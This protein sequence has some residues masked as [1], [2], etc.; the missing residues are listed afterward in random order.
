MKYTTEIRRHS[1]V[2]DV[3]I[4]HTI[5]V[6]KLFESKPNF[7]ASQYEGLNTKMVYLRKLRHQ[8]SRLEDPVADGFVFGRISKCKIFKDLKRMSPTFS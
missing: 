5:S 1:L 7:S 6:I 8:F 3:Y 4:W 2:F